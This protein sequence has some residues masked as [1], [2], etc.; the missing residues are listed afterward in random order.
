MEEARDVLVAWKSN[1]LKKME[2]LYQI[3]YRLDM[4]EEAYDLLSDLIKN[5][6]DEMDDE[7]QTNLSAIEASLKLAGS[8]SI[9]LFKTFKQ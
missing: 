2:L 3:H 1:S 8:V 9:F 5:S 4:F 6:D 7:R